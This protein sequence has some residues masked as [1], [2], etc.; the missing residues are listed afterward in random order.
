MLKFLQSFKSLPSAWLLAVQ[1]M[2]LFTAPLTHQIFNHHAFAWFLGTLALLMVAQIIR[3]TAIYTVI[4][5]LCVIPA[6]VLSLAVMLGAD[7]P[8]I[9]IT[10]HLFE[11]A[12]YLCAAYGLTRYMF[13]D[14]YLTRD[15]LFAVA[16]VFTLL[17]WAF[18][19]MYSACQLWDVNSFNLDNGQAR[20][21]V[22]LIFI[23]FSV[24]TGTGLSD[25]VPQSDMARVLVSLQMFGAVMYLALIVSRLIALQYIRHV[26]RKKE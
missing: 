9:L 25:I 16:S 5:M 15:E 19:F 4:G 14:R 23:S 21:W 2:M 1:L 7:S 13:D 26:P 10:A 3:V 17:V 24:Q 22:D 18:A 20:S 6:L 11:A 8:N 12:A